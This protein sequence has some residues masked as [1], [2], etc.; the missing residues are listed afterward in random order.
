MIGG[1]LLI[2]A[3]EA[4]AGSAIKRRGFEH[5]MRAMIDRAIGRLRTGYGRTDRDIVRLLLDEVQIFELPTSG[6]A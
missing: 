1:D 5:R 4:A 2:K 3:T 6:H